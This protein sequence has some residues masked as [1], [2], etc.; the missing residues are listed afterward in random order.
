MI[1]KLLAVAAVT[2]VSAGLVAVVDSE[3]VRA[4]TCVTVPA[5]AH[6]GG[7]ERYV[8]N[9]RDSFRD[10][11]NRGAGVWETDVQ[12][13]ADNVPVILHDDTIDRTTNGTGA[14]ADLTATQLATARTADDQPVPTLREFVNDVQVDGV[15]ALVE[16][17]VPPTEAQWATFLAALSSR[18]I[19]SKIVVTSFDGSVLVAARAH[20]SAYATG[21]ITELGDQSVASVTQYAGTRI[22]IKHHNAITWSR[23]DAWQAGGLSVYSWTVDTASEWQRMGSYPAGWMDGVITN[24]PGGYLAW[25]RGRVC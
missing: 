12:F 5:V 3:P 2:S 8:E 4:A 24:E 14:V 19:T 10:A 16:L 23:L 7:T 17:K 1:R 20:S 11:T 21:L 13:T 15:R 22:L 9:T 18:P 6:R 25:Q